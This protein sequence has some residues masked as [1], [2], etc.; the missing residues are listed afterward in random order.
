MDGLLKRGGERQFPGE[1]A[2]RLAGKQVVTSTVNTG[3]SFSI[4]LN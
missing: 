4:W 3:C 1:Q 2:A